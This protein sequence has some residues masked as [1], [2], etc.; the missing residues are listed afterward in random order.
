MKEARSLNDAMTN[1]LPGA[2]RVERPSLFTKAPADGEVRVV[3]APPRCR[4]VARR[5]AFF[6]A[7]LWGCFGW[8]ATGAQP[9]PTQG[10]DERTAWFT[11]AHYGMFIHWGLFSVPAGVYHGKPFDRGSA[12]NGLSE[13]IMFNAHIPV[14]EYAGYASQFNPVK[15][16][17]D[18]WVRLAKD[19][20]M[21]Y[22]V[23]TTKHHEGFAM[24]HSKVSGFNIYDATPFHRDPLKELAA[25]CARQGVRLG[26]YYS[27][28]QDWHH[29]GGAARTVGQPMAGGD[30]EQ[31]HWDP[32]QDGDF[33]QYLDQV[34]APQIRELLT[35]Y[36]KISTFWW[37]TPVGM[38]S[39]RA[40][41]LA[42]L[43][44]LQPGIISNN[45]LLNPRV[46]NAFSG[47]TET[48]E[49]YIPA[50]GMKG[51]LFEVCMTMNDSWGY[52]AN[53]HNWKSAEDLTRKLIDVVSK[54]GNLLLNVGPDAEG[55]IPAASVKRLRESG[56]WVHAHAESIYGTTASLFRRLSWG[57]S[58]TKGNVLF[59][60]IFQ[61]P[62]DGRLLVPGLKTPIARATLLDQPDFALSARDTAA[63]AVL[64]LP[65]KTPNKIA[66]VIK[67][68]FHGAPV[69]DQPLPAPDTHGVILLPASLAAVVNAYDDNASLRTEGSDAVIGGWSKAGTRLNW[70]FATS[71]A[72]TF[73]ITAEV[74]TKNGGKI[75]VS[76]G[77]S[78][79]TS[80]LAPGGEP[81][82]FTWV[83]LGELHVSGEGEH[84]IELKSVA[85]A[86]NPVK[87]R[88]L[89]LEEKR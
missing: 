5:S 51:R 73:V 11:A 49:Q 31:G 52:K 81:E 26:L 74:A 58:T 10:L 38:T 28:A 89:R 87:L 65:A 48:P 6:L 8:H 45:R 78:T 71:L 62:V 83:R 39:T 7:L 61:W 44:Q 41:R 13:W 32:A 3:A 82:H 37:D 36:G 85:D 33:D 46:P 35:R 55:V 4:G 68:E 64:S 29:P 16:D 75:E 14:A 17:A 23:I 60:H 63:G 18:A 69:V 56:R 84:S 54:G 22:I 57:R 25:A 9:V 42:P 30:P 59:L 15:F 34:A 72:A 12:G 88:A 70:E 27:Q 79:F 80:Q 77:H 53:D 66:A 24:F 86:W 20:G 1:R 67:L 76:D 47:D 21:K 19:A 50:T 2:G 40:A 43:L